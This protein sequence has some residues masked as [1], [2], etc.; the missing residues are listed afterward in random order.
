[1]CYTLVFN[2]RVKFAEAWGGHW[3]YNRVEGVKLSYSYGFTPSALDDDS[4]ILMKADVANA[5]L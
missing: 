2:C 5:A 3:E 4:L 1:M